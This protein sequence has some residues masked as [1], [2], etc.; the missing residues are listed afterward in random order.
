MNNRVSIE[1]LGFG[2]GLLLLLTGCANAPQA[3]QYSDEQPKLILNDFL[4]GHLNAEGLFKDRSG[5]VV[6][7]FKV[8]MMAQWQGPKGQEQGILDEHFI[9]LDHAHQGLKQQRVWHLTRVGE[10]QGMTYFE[11]RADDVIGVAKGESAGNTLHWHYKLNLP[12]DGHDIEVDMDDWMYLM[13]PRLMLNQAV[14]SKWGIKLGE[15][16]IVFEKLEE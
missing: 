13:T 2:I 12:V 6:R 5:S 9:Y 14:M 7:R 10:D 3:I 11:G 8:D 1:I 4:N 15:V 16:Q